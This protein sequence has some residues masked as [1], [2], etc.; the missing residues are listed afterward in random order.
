MKRPYLVDFFKRSSAFINGGPASFPSEAVLF[1][2]ACVRA[3]LPDGVP[4][5]FDM[6]GDDSGW[7]EGF[8]ILLHSFNTEARLDLVGLAFAKNFVVEK[9]TT[10][11]R[12]VHAWRALPEGV[13]DSV[14]IRRPIF[15]LGL[16]RTGS[17]FLFNLLKEVDGVRVP[18]SWEYRE[19][20]PGEGQPTGE[21]HLERMRVESED[22]KKLMPGIEDVHNFGA[23][24][25]AE[26]VE[27]MGQEFDGPIF[28]TFYNVASHGAWMFY[29]PAENRSHVMRH[30]RRYLQWLQF[31]SGADESV[32]RSWVLKAP[33]WAMMIESIERWYPDALFV[34]THRDPLAAAGSLASLTAKSQGLSTS[35]IDNEASLKALGPQMVHFIWESARRMLEARQRWKNDTRMSTRFFDVQL[36]ELKRDPVGTVAK[37]WEHFG[38]ERLNDKSRH[39]MQQWLATGQVSHGK[40]EAA[41]PETYGIDGAWREDPVFKDYCAEFSVPSC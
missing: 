10:R 4:C 13:L 30:H 15:I 25:G 2:E 5:E 22:Y 38:R 14:E 6:P 29:R 36:G 16:P 21:A 33:F 9:L 20:I 1:A 39:R 7:K 8:A 37:I 3:K 32:P 41:P 24:M 18:L 35:A 26:C 11:A 19:P 23:E 28:S 17:T 31:G 27:V 12:L 34:L 40:H